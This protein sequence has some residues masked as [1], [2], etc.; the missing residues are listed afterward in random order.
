LAR[1]FVSYRRSDS[2]GLPASTV[3]AEL[4]R[5]FSEDEIYLDVSSNTPGDPWPDRIRD[6]V[7]NCLV[8][9]AVVGPQYATGDGQENRL[10]DPE[11]W[12]RR[13]VTS[14]LEQGK[15][16]IP[17]LAGASEFP[18][19][20]PEMAMLT[21]LHWLKAEQAKFPGDE[22]ARAVVKHA[23]ELRDALRAP[24]SWEPEIWTEPRPLEHLYGRESDVMQVSDAVL[25]RGRQVVLV[26]GPGGMGKTSVVL[27]A[28]ARV[29]AKASFSRLYQINLENGQPA[30]D[31]IERLIRHFSQNTVS[32]L[33]AGVSERIAVLTRLM[34]EHRCIVILENAER[35][36]ASEGGDAGYRELLRNLSGQIIGSVVFV[37]SREKLEVARDIEPGGEQHELRPIGADACRAL[38]HVRAPDLAGEAHEWE[39]FGSAHGGNPLHLKLAADEA[40]RLG[41]SAVSQYLAKFPVGALKELVLR[42]TQA[43][44]ERERIMLATL[45]AARRPLRRGEAAATAAK[46]SADDYDDALSVLVRRYLAEVREAGAISLQP[47]VQEEVTA[48]MSGWA[49]DAIQSRTPG[50]LD[51]VPLMEVRAGEQ[52]VEAQRRIN[53]GRIVERAESSTGMSPRALGAA[54]EAMLASLRGTSSGYAAGNIVNIL[55][56]VR[57]GDLSDADFSGLVLREVHLRDA[58]LRGASLVGT[59]IE[60]AVF[61]DTFGSIWMVAFSPDG[62]SI[63]SAGVTGEI[64]VWDARSGEVRTGFGRHTGWSFGL[65]YSSDGAWIASAGGDQDVRLWRTDT[66]SAG[67]VLGGHTSRVRAVAFH[68]A[69]H[70]LASASED[71][72]VIRWK[73]GFTSAPQPLELFR[74][75]ARL[76]A[77]CFSGDGRWLFAAGGSGKICI[78]DTLSDTLAP[79]IDT[80]GTEVRS[81]AASGDG[82]WLASVGDRETAKIWRVGQWD[83]PAFE[84]NASAPL[85][86]VAVRGGDIPLVALGGDD[87]VIR[88]W[89]GDAPVPSHSWSAHANLV[90]SVDI[91][92]DGTQIASGGDDQT[93]RVFGVTGGGESVFKGYQCGARA[94]A[95]APGG[96]LLASGHDDAVIRLWDAQT[97]Q[98]LRRFSGHKSRIWSLAWSGDGE[99]LASG[100]EDGAVRVWSGI[101]RDRPE[102]TRPAHSYRV[103]AVAVRAGAPGRADIVASA[104][105]DRTIRFW[106]LRSGAPAGGAL[107]THADRVRDITFSSGGEL[108]ASGDETGR[109]I[110]WREEDGEWREGFQLPGHAKAVTSLKFDPAGRLLYSGSEDRSMRV[111]DLERRREL[112]VKENAHTR[113]VLAL[114]ISRDGKLVASGSEDGSVGLWRADNLQPLFSNTLHSDWVESVSFSGDG[115]WLASASD[116]QDVH[117]TAVDDGARVSTLRDLPPYHGLRIS[118]LTGIS[119]DQRSA[120]EALGAVRE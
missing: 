39:A 49:L 1:I 87:G 23:P 90:R 114:D 86:S 61:G 100:S 13:E 31:V 53:V 70:W 40:L 19:L 56:A 80:G 96:R 30:G 77:L 10:L 35:V 48:L 60:G 84:L 29:R 18:A 108:L 81:I 83:A 69:D 98:V 24:L 4:K 6:G 5:F 85:R 95:F 106:S 104:G 54:G 51:R 116:D 21:T 46:A 91:S 79:P 92:P 14:A 88:V 52:V 7:A 73:R 37:T 17:V 76:T 75:D 105:A 27:A 44:R 41:F 67:E 71:H 16:V 3:Y 50:I 43:L 115:L 119:A 42:H 12:V 74:H 103:F 20:P 89:S 33:P 101:E 99:R 15:A 47:A 109:I 9:I 117:V 120:L 107:T 110:V 57:G 65:A 113:Q 38:V 45:A 55:C 93:V 97:G 58:V 32:A 82:C 28:L 8:L 59:H 112:C 94:A 63:A 72:S 36:L 102:W 118:G 25:R 2:S 78:W 11:D 68:P 26:H 66:P 111:W 22:L 62:R 34:S 64:R